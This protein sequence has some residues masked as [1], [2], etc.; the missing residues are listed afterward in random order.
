MAANPI[1]LRLYKVLG[2]NFDDPATADALST[3]ASFYPE[4]NDP[5]GTT[6]T[7]ALARKNLRR[8]IEAKLALESSK[9]LAAFAQVDQKLDV[10]QAH[11]DEMRIKC[12]DAQEHLDKTNDA[13][14]YLLQRADAIKLQKQSVAEKQAIMAVFLKRFTLSEKE[15]EAIMS[16]DVPLGRP[17]FDAMDHCERMRD[18]CRLL[19]SGE[20]SSTKAGLVYS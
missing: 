17:V 16:R 2:A 18:D 8:D 5:N 3:L 20:G 15:I 7:A 1:N 9:F 6:S 4:T 14:K 10:L 13:C 12:D 19:L 11:V